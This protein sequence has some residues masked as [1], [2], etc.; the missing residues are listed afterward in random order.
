MLGIIP[1]ISYCAYVQLSHIEVR[2]YNRSHFY[3]YLDTYF[4]LRSF[5]VNNSFMSNSYVKN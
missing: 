5:C 2:I 3:I 1:A 4:R